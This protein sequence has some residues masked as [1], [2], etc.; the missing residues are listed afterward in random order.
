MLP[1]IESLEKRQLLSSIPTGGSLGLLLREHTRREAATAQDSITVS[2]EPFTV[3]NQLPSGAH[4][5][6]SITVIDNIGVQ[7]SFLQSESGVSLQIV[8]ASEG[9]T[10]YSLDVL[11]VPVSANMYKALPRAGLSSETHVLNT[12]A[13]RTTWFS[14]KAI[15]QAYAEADWHKE[16]WEVFEAVVTK[17]LALVDLGSADTV[18]FLWA[19]L[20]SDQAKE[21][22]QLDSLP[23]TTNP[24]VVSYLKEQIEGVRR[25]VD[26]L[27]LTTGYHAT[28]AT[29][30]DLLSFYGSAITTDFTRDLDATLAHRK[31]KSDDTFIVQSATDS[32]VWYPAQVVTE[33]DGVPQKETTWG[34]SLDDMDRLSYN[35]EI[36]RKLTDIIARFLNV[37]GYYAPP[38]PA[39]FHKNGRLD[40]EVAL[41]VPRDDVEWV[42]AK[43]T[44]NGQAQ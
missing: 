30:L 23:A 5:D 31:I 19:K 3:S 9:S 8:P 36:D 42:T 6:R 41:Y 28:Y 32:S 37:D 12:Y 22:Q 18:G 13:S 14:S 20:E 21:K 27:E 7:Q 25:D 43:T 4:I 29:Q 35:T 1:E 17:P 44:N 39:L 16:P 40:E 11:N 34:G 38:L 2:K 10:T 15:A 26:I 33:S 24:R